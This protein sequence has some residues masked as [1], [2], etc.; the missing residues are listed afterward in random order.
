MKR[1]LT[2]LVLFSVLLYG[3]ASRSSS[4]TPTP[5]ASGELNRVVS[6]S[7][8]VVPATWAA[9]S[10]RIGGRLSAVRVQEGQKV[11]AGQELAVLDSAELELAVRA[12]AEEVAVQQAQLAQAQ[13]TP[14]AA[15]LAAAQAELG[16]AKTALHDLEE[17]PKPRDL[18]EA[19]LQL[20]QAKNT[21]WAIQ[22]EGDVPG[23][24]LTSQ[25]AAHARAAAA[26]QVVHLAE[27][28][29]ER[30]KEG[31]PAEALASARAAVAQ[32]EAALDALQR[33]ASPEKL[34][35]LRAAIR[36]AQVAVEQAQWQLS[37]AI[38]VAP[39]AGTVTEVAARAGEM[40]ASGIPVF[41]LADLNTLRVETTDLDEGDL[42]L[43][44]VGQAT[45]I[46]FDALPN[47]VLSGHVTHIAE[48]STV[49]QGGNSFVLWIELDKPDPRLRWG[50]SAFVDVLVQ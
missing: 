28:Q 18:E 23:L 16:A 25:Q 14:A 29:Y 48:M 2:L 26:E 32:A 34:D 9:L 6:V 37:Q 49:G 35:S 30:V 45:E 22:L 13:T 42:P 12:A 39:F 36:R 4:P 17:M 11:E 31:A 20:E 41:V 46:T 8:K 3:C 47:E 40:V 50:M 7:G 10:F 15:D 1:A 43:L 27:L 44:Q 5:A 24:P 19:R 38:L 33:G 21:L